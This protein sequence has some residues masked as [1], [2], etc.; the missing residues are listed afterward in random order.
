MARKRLAVVP[1]GYTIL[2]I[3]DQ[4]AILTSMRL[5]LEHEGHTVRTAQSGPAGLTSFRE[6]LAQLVIVDYRMPE[7]TGADVIQALRRFDAHVPILLQ[8][9]DTGKQD[10]SGLLR[11]LNIQGFHDKG[12]GPDRLLAWVDTLLSSSPSRPQPVPLRTL[13][14]P[15]WKDVRLPI[16]LSPVSILSAA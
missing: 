1:S 3:D 4:D 15:R 6:Q 5:L 16:A 2:V 7:M 8:S 13:P 9:G 10:V 14:P 11:Q 12:D